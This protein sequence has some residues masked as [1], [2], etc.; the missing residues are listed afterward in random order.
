M[1]IAEI[2]TLKKVSQQNEMHARLV[3]TVVST[4]TCISSAD[5][6]NPSSAM[7]VV[8]RDTRPSIVTTRNLAMKIVPK[9]MRATQ[10]LESKK[11]SPSFLSGQ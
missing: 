3:G 6:A 7:G 5:M 2:Y 11:Y 9:T 8:M 4:I 1:F 10:F